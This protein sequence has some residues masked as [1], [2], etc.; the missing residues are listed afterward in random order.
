[1]LTRVPGT[2]EFA[3]DLV[4]EGLG[5]PSHWKSENTRSVYRIGNIEP[6]SLRHRSAAR[7][8]L[9]SLRGSG[10]MWSYSYA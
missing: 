8:L 1:M 6:C 4:R 5:L 2:V 9:D 10:R 3:V 7:V